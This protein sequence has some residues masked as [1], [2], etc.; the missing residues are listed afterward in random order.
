MG[1]WPPARSGHG[2]AY[3]MKSSLY[4]FGGRTNDSVLLEMN[5]MWQFNLQTNQWYLISAQSTL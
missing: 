4:V 2:M 3:D 1:R 5:D